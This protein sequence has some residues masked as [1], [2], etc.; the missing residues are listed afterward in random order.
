MMEAIAG[1]NILC[2]NYTG[3][4]SDTD[5]ALSCLFLM[6]VLAISF[7]GYVTIEHVALLPIVVPW[8]QNEVDTAQL[9]E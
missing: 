4:V 8:N 6:G 1:V 3:T 2:V 9:T 7:I 5:A